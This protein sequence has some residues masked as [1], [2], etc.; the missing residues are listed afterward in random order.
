VNTVFTCFNSVYIYHNHNKQQ[1]KIASN[2]KGTIPS[3]SKTRRFVK[4]LCMED[5]HKT[6]ACLRGS[7]RGLIYYPGICLKGMRK[8]MKNLSQDGHCFSR[9]VNR[10]PPKYKS[11]AVISSNMQLYACPPTHPPTTYL[12]TYLPTY[13]MFRH[14]IHH[15]S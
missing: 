4:S 12:P 1:F 13:I 10:V 7:T 6:P 11:R 2:G 3:W 15:L 8:I 9:Y 5:R 14:F